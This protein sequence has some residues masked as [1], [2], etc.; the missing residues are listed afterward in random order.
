MNDQEQNQASVMNDGRARHD[1]LMPALMPT[2]LFEVIWRSR[3]I[4]LACVVAA[5]VAGFVYVLKATPIFMSTSRVYVE[6]TGP[7]VMEDVQGVMTQSKNY[8]YTQAEMIK[9]TPIISMAVEKPEIQRLRTFQDVT[10]KV[11]FLKHSL[12]VSVGKKDDILSVGIESPYPAEAS[13]IVNT[14]VDA[15]IT[16][17]STTKK[18]TAAE[19]LKILQKQ[20]D[21]AVTELESK[22][23]SMLTYQ[24]ANPALTF[25]T[26]QGNI[27]IERLAKLSESLTAAELRTIEAKSIYESIGLL[28]KDPARLRQFTEAQRLR[29]SYSGSDSESSRLNGQLDELRIQID[30]RKKQVTDDHPAVVSLQERYRSVMA[31]LQLVDEKYAEAQLAVAKQ[32]YESAVDSEKQIRQYFD[33]QR[34]EATGLNQQIS[35]YTVL[36]SDVARAENLLAILDDRIKAVNVTEDTGA[37]NISILEVARPEEIPVKPQKARILAMALVLGLMAG[38]GLAM[39]RDFMDHRLRS[40]DEITAVLGVPVLGTVPSM[41]RRQ[42]ISQRGM[43]VHKETTSIAA[44]SYRTIRT[45]I[46]FGVPDGRAKVILVTSP[47]P[48]DGKTTL[49]SNIAIAM[50]QADQKTLLIDADFRKP[51]QHNVFSL[52]ADMGLSTLIAGRGRLE[53]CIQS[54]GV[55]GL[56]VLPAGPE[57]PNPSEMLN[58][59][60]FGN[61]LANLKQRFDRIII[62]SPPVMPVTDA[63]IL[64][65]MCDVTVVVLR[66]EQSTRKA[67]MQARDGL[68]SVGGSILGVV[69]NDVSQRD[70]HYGY[71][72]RYGYAYYGRRGAENTGA[73]VVQS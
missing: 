13:Q 44:E 61:L 1:S 49:A 22:R 63:K 54:P 31:E 58:S 71:Y 55:S 39:A 51:M 7:K 30:D 73:S 72:S 4:V 12:D 23:D 45:A 70:G 25:E 65:V 68:L 5:L 14:I 24:K 46:F 60:A 35:E 47:M 26:S 6:Q 41:S 52:N 64:A 59:Q 38:G 57:I 28:A 27:A 34:K 15:Y 48:G 3:W 66:A 50:S 40:A 62:D 37:L 53:E 67:A 21:K 8:L 33:E 10:N 17:N 69:V 9:S 43:V 36:R 19:V 16:Y 11:T 20:K 56:W 42:S 32:D 2:S 18:S 29:S